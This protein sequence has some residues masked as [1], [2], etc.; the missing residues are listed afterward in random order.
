VAQWVGVESKGECGGTSGMKRE[1]ERERGREREGE[2]DAFKIENFHTF[3]LFVS[4]SFVETGKTTEGDHSGTAYSYAM[5]GGKRS[6]AAKCDREEKKRTEINGLGEDWNLTGFT[7]DFNWNY[8][9]RS[10]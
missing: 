5:R 1:R 3:S 4:Q 9:L 2:G 10:L 6:T 7:L 8:L